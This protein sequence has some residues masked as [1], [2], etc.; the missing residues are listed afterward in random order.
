[1]LIAHAII[2]TLDLFNKKV[3]KS[4]QELDFSKDL[5]DLYVNKI[6]KKVLA[7]SKK[8]KGKFNQTSKLYNLVKTFNK[9]TDFIKFSHKI[10]DLFFEELSNYISKNI[11]KDFNPIARK[12]GLCEFNDLCRVDAPNINEDYSK[13]FK[14]NPNVFKKQN[15]F[16]S[17]Y[18]DIYSHYKNIC[19]RPFKK[20]NPIEKARP[21]PCFY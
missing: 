2:N 21:E 17:E 5:T 14:Q 16:N 1:M 13:A 9:D 10:S 8:R 19:D 3:N 11:S 20:F 7:S 18:Y 6:V 12:K 15:M 4:N